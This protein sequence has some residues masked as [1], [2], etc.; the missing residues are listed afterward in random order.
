[1]S[2]AG[3]M[4]TGVLAGAELSSPPCAEGL[5][6]GVPP[7]FSAAGFADNP[8]TPLDRWIETHGTTPTPAPPRKGEG[9]TFRFRGS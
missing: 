1:M 3:A 8:E 5:G 2:E 6:V 9:T 4:I 7:C